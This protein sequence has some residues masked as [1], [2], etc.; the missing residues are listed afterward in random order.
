MQCMLLYNII[1]SNIKT[2]INYIIIIVIA[3]LQA[4]MPNACRSLA[5]IM[6]NK[7]VCDN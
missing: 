2:T 5:I 3:I 1:V 4:Y 7:G 6:S